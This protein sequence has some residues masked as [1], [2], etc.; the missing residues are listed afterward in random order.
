MSGKR[1]CG[2]ENI[3]R[4]RRNDERQDNQE[5]QNKKE[6]TIQR[7]AQAHPAFEARGAESWRHSQLVITLLNAGWIGDRGGKFQFFLK[8]V[9]P[10]AAGIMEVIDR[11]QMRVESVLGIQATLARECFRIAYN[12]SG[13]YLYENYPLTAW[14][15][16]CRCSANPRSSLHHGS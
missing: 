13:K 9:T 3:S 5:N 7:A 6:T 1:V 8:G 15:L 10:T 4:I 11:E 14:L 2:T 16:R 12:T